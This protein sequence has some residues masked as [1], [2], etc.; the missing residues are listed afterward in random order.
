MNGVRFYSQP[1]TLE[2][3]NIRNYFTANWDAMSDRRS[4]CG[5][6]WIAAEISARGDVTP[7]HTFYDLTIGNIY[8][9]SLSRSGVGL[10]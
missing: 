8:E 10:G 5:V 1:R 6:P 4:R 7:C 2:V 9:Q 3:S